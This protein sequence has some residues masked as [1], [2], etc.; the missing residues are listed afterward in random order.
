MRGKDG[1]FG[2]SR[3]FRPAQPDRH[4]RP[5]D[6]PRGALVA[7]ARRDRPRPGHG[8]ACSTSGSARSCRSTPIPHPTRG[9]AGSAPG[10]GGTPVLPA[11]DPAPA[12]RRSRQRTLTVVGIAASVS[13]P[14]VAAWLSPTDLTA[15]A[16]PDVPP[17]RQM[18]YRVDPSATAADLTAAIARI[19]AG[20]ATDDVAS[21]TTYLQTKADVDTIAQLYVPVLLAFSIFA[22]LAAAFTIANVVG[23]IVLT[24]Y[25]DIGVM[26][27]VGF[28]P[29]QVTAIL[30]TQILVPVAIGASPGWSPGSSPASRWSR[31]PPSRSGSR[32]PSRSRR[33][34]SSLVLT[35][36]IAVA[37]LAAIGPAI[38]AGRLSAVEAITRGTAPSRRS[39]G[40]RLRG[41]GLR[42]PIGV[43]A[44]LG[45]AAGVAHPVRAAM[46][47]GALVVGVA[48]VTFAVGMNLSLL[49]VEDQLDRVSA[50]PV[51]VE[52]AD[53]SADQRAICRGHRRD[54]RHRSLRRARRDHGER[55][56]ARASS[57]SSDMTATRAGS[58]TT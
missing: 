30:L 3:S 28:T 51:R 26:K 32:A 23:G 15:L 55:A 52:L 41:L 11:Q 10:G 56:R 49:R 50:S 46:T 35:V 43:P 45:V 16:G 38:D 7:G 33:P 29:G 20:L 13:T 22:L 42:L 5:R 14:D 27:A 58:A 44:R 31:A 9:A 18:L 19:T 37:L 4:H 25:R 17:D 6:D 40:G 48:A 39:D 54:A 12:D 36:S 53:P 24:S 8:H 57:R 21:S 1:I 47:L 34:W 2:G